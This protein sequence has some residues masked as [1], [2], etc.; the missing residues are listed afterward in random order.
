MGKIP[1]NVCTKLRFFNRANG[2]SFSW[3]ID[4]L[5]AGLNNT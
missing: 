5:C 4:Y 1:K 3:I 2:G